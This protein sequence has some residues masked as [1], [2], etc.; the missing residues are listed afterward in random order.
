M[1]NE[2]TYL[3]ENITIETMEFAVI[4]IIVFIALYLV[5]TQENKIDM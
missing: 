2:S 4:I 1:L 3:T 5:K